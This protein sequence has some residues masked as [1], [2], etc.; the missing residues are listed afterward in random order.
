MKRIFTFLVMLLAVAG[1][2]CQGSNNGYTVNGNISGLPENAVLQFVPLSH[3]DQ[4]PVGEAVVKKG[5]FTFKGEAPEPRGF[6]IV[7]KN[8]YGS[9]TFVAANGEKVNI[10]GQVTSSKER[11]GK[12][13]YDFKGVKVSGSP[14]TEKYSKLMSARDELDA[15]F[16][17]MQRRYANI[18]KIFSTQGQSPAVI[19]SVRKTA[20][21][22]QMEEE[23]RQLFETANKNYRK[24]VADNK[25]TFWGPMMMIAYLSYLSPDNR[26]EYQALS[27]AA[28]NSYYG[29]M[30]RDELYPLGV[31]GDAVPAFSGTLYDGKKTT[32][33]ELCKGKK[34]VLVDFWASWCKPC[35]KEIPNIKKI[36]D[37]HKA[38]GF[39]IVSVSIDENEGQWRKAVEKEALVWP[40]L[41]DTDKSIA[42]NYHVSSVPTMYIID[43][44]GRLVAENL[45]GEE[46][47]AKIDELMTR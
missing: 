10:E 31:P 22:K 11:D 38:N 42:K 34:Y 37:K 30:V 12:V 41:R 1:I 35:R 17:E 47:A 45:R 26:A 4:T 21:Y 29:K 6:L 20:E 33:A 43:G 18:H 15:R 16:G 3:V 44:N 46:L 5:K 2:S 39:D 13:M 7:V 25:D 19:D 9:L 28:K 23:E 40:N 14:S 27:D 8:N 32:L 36:Y 24:V